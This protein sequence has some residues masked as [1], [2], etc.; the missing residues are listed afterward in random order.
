MENP[1]RSAWQLPPFC[2]W[3]P[4][5]KLAAWL[6]L[7]TVAAGAVEGVCFVLGLPISL[8]LQADGGRALLLVIAI[9]TLFGLMAVDRRPL[10]EYGLAV[11]IGWRRQWGFGLAAGLATYS[12]YCL[13]AAGTGAARLSGEH[14]TA[15]RLAT[16]IL[17]GMTAIPLAITQQ[18]IFSGYL[19]SLFRL[20]HGPLVGVVVSAAL[21]SLAT[22]LDQPSA[23]LD[24]AQARWFFG[25]FVIAA[26][27]G[28]MRLAHGGILLPAGVLA[29][30]L[31]VRR[32][33]R[34]THLLAVGSP[35]LA[36][37]WFPAEDPRLAPVLWGLVA[38]ATAIYAWRL[39]RH[40]EPMVA[41]QPSLATDFKRV[42]P[43]S[44]VCMLAPLDLW[45]GR[46]RAAKFRVDPAY[47]PRLAAI[48]LFSSLNTLLSLPERW[49]LP[50]LLRRRSVPDPVFILGVHR[51]GTTHLHNLLALDPQFATPRAYQIMNPTGYM[52]LGWLLTPLL[53]AFSPWKRP[54]DSVRFHIFSP[55]EEEF[56]LAGMTHLSPYWG[57]TFPRQWAEYDRYIAIDRLPNAELAAWKYRYLT[58]L[59]KLVLW[60][61]KRPLL[62]NPYNTARLRILRQMFPQARFVHIYR[63]PYAVY[64]SN[65]HMAREGHCVYQL[66]DPDP[67]DNYATRFLA[68]YRGMEDLLYRDAADLPVRQ[69]CEVRYEEL[70]REPLAIIRRM[71]AQLGLEFTAE[72]ATRLT[73]YLETVKDYEK[74]RFRS[75]PPDEQ[76]RIHAALAPLFDRWGYPAPQT[77]TAARTAA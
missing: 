18:A 60:S 24:P 76:A 13:L 16:A 44:N 59:R 64:R 4:A 30:W 51:S 32:V 45:M 34:R 41:T 61:G 26:L 38:L 29:G 46:L 7:S 56:A 72:F 74:N 43:F 75:L 65:V 28:T 49:L 39:L 36:D 27:L 52:F 69:W 77:V 10:A 17:A 57:L 23:L 67:L 35:E 62:K 66:Q 53:G 54:M 20:R 15:Y 63:D 6:L 1:S 42:A 70:D 50:R 37:W 21:F 3:H 5:A 58:F 47:L 25:M 12:S 73:E 68:N 2:A 22:R 71:Y 11:G 48:L 19:L 8:R 31:F 14:V 33:I 40:G 55:N 9:T